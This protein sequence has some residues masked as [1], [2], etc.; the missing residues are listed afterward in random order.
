[1]AA[2]AA[3]ALPLLARLEALLI[4]HDA[5]AKA[6]FEALDGTLAAARPTTLLRLRS[7]VESYEFDEALAALRE[8]VRDLNLATAPGGMP[9]DGRAAP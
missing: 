1:V 3:S 8:V 9:A 7:A 5:E 2:D 6:A 4:D